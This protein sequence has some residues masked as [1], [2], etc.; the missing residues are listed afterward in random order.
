M[1]TRERLQ[2]HLIDKFGPN[3]YFQHRHEEALVWLCSEIDVL[4][5]G[6]ASHDNRRSEQSASSRTDV[7]P[8]P[9]DQA[10][11]EFIEGTRI[12]PECVYDRFLAGESIMHLAWD[13][14]LPPEKI[15]DVVRTC[16]K[17]L[18]SNGAEESEPLSKT[19]EFVDGWRVHSAS[20]GWK[21]TDSRRRP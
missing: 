10:G 5:G 18:A 12:P 17:S 19:E 13:F 15:E 6:D 9:V 14:H 4:K 1:T 11:G 3:T 7:A 20:D 8:P 2:Q 21:G 16:A